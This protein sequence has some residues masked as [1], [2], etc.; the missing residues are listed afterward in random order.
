MGKTS[1]GPVLW[2]LTRR[3]L[4]SEI[5]VLCYVRVIYQYL[6]IPF[7]ISAPLDTYPY[8]ANLLAHLSIKKTPFIS[9]IVSPFGRLPLSISSSR[10]PCISH[11]ISPKYIFQSVWQP[12]YESELRANIDLNEALRISMSQLLPQSLFDSVCNLGEWAFMPFN[13]VHVRRG[14]KVHNTNPEAVLTPFS[15]Y[16]NTIVEYCDKATALLLVGDSHQQIVD[17]G[18]ALS[19]L[20]YSNVHLR[21]PVSNHSCLGYDQ[22]RFNK[23]SLS[24]KLL[25]NRA[26][27][28]DFKSLLHAHVLI[29]SHSSCVGRCASILRGSLPTISVDTPLCVVQ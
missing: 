2:P 8:W 13:T 25:Y 23:L 21:S 26:F 14:D 28:D 11:Y 5:L 16:I 27:L 29:C 7:Q 4:F 17:L 9:P 19:K 15:C 3:G 24:T 22:Q 6:D 12:R 10:I 18:L 20:G 1:F